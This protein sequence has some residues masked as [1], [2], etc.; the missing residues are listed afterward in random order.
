L[1]NYCRTVNMAGDPD[2]RMREVMYEVLSR[3]RDVW[4]IR[5]FVCEIGVHSTTPKGFFMLKQKPLCQLEE[6]ICPSA[7]EWRIDCGCR[8]DYV[9]LKV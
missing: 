9:S 5:H 3:Y 7:C 8:T 4:R 6:I 2:R 1:L